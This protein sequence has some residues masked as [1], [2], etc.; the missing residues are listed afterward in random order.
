MELN[1]ADECPLEDECSPLHGKI[2]KWCGE[3]WNRHFPARFLDLDSVDLICSAP[4][5]EG[6]RIYVRAVAANFG[7][8][9]IHVIAHPNRQISVHD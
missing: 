9:T 5:M 6:D 3:K 2:D 4:K 8:L 7:K 1:I